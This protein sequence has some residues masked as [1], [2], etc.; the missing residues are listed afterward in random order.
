VVEQVLKFPITSPLRLTVQVTR[1]NPV[2]MFL[3][4]SNKVE[5][6]KTGDRRATYCG[7]FYA[8]KTTTFQHTERL[9]QGTYF[10][11]IRDNV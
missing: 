5:K 8:V 11:V 7:A 2:E 3:T 4:D 6:L 1:G 9:T 10:F